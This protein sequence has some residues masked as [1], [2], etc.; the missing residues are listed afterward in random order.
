MKT[1]KL[2]VFPIPIYFNMDKSRKDYPFLQHEVANQH[3]EDCVFCEHAKNL[4]KKAAMRGGLKSDNPYRRA[5]G[6]DSEMWL[7]GFESIKVIDAQ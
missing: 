5:S 1:V 3:T 7:E 2:G 4:G 6:R